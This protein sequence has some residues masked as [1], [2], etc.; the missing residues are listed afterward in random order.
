MKSP[1]T[2]NSPN[3]DNLRLRLIFGFSGFFMMMGGILWFDWSYFVVFLVIS[4]AMQ[5]EFYQMLKAAGHR[6]LSWLGLGIGLALYVISFLNQKIALSANYYLLIH[7]GF[8]L[9]FLFKLFDSEDKK[10]FD[11][12]AYTLLGVVYVMLPFAAL[13][14]AVFH[15]GYYSYQIIMGCFF[16][17]WIN[18]IGAYFIGS[19]YGKTPLFPRISPKKSWQGSAGGAFL[20]FIMIFLLSHYM[21]DLPAW[22]WAVIA[23]IVVVFGTLGDLVE[24]LLKRG[25]DRKDASGALPGHGGFLDRFDN[26]TLVAPLVAAFLKLL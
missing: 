24:S 17:I 19:N 4:L 16:L 13:H 21:Q 7:A 12:I 6:P 2:T 1:S 8:L 15:L 14:Y 5:V 20:A 11:S 9:V 22:R 23:L 10:P 18:D 26:L 25:L 3:K